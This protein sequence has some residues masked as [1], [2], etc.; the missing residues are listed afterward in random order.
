MSVSFDWFGRADPTTETC[1]KDGAERI[2]AK[3][4]A[5][6]AERGHDVFVALESRGYH[7]SVRAVR[8]ELRS[9]LVNGLPPGRAREQREMAE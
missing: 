1:D 5:Y 8:Y 9:N 3:I 6:W 4:E 7:P 2:K